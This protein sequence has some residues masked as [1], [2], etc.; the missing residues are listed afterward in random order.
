MATD[1]SVTVTG[2]ATK[3]PEV[4]FTGGGSQVASF[5]VAVNRRWQ[6][7]S[8]NEWEEA[9]SYFDVSCWNQLSANVAESVGRG[10][11]VTV[12]GRLEQR[13]WETKEGDRR[14]K[15]EIVADDVAISLKWAT[16][17]VMR[18]ERND[19]GGGGQ[20]S[21]GQGGGY[22][23]GQS[24]QGGQTTGGQP[25]GQSN[26]GNQAGG[27]SFGGGSQEAPPAYNPDEEPF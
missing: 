27:R 25:S 11:R 7:R 19:Q 4:R 12:T 13:S 10:T 26:Y 16:A 18:N 22:G 6:N 15:I 17:N 24:N 14:S 5:S 3:E 2:N 20:N 9:V 23:G 8:T 1:N 21:G